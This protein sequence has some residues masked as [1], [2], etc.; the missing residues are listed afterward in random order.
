MLN[1]HDM[2][3]LSELFSKMNTLKQNMVNQL[4][5]TLSKNYIELIE[6]M[7]KLKNVDVDIENCKD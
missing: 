4:D 1:N 7:E 3:E 5:Q 6:D 2:S